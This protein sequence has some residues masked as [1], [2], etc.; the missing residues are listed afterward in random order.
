MQRLASIK[1]YETFTIIAMFIIYGLVF[2][3]RL[4]F[5]LLFPF[6]REDLNLSNTQLGLM[7][8]VY[9]LFWGISC[10]F[11][12]L[13]S[14]I[15]K[16]RKR[17][18]ITLLF[19]FGLA[20]M[21]VGIITSVNVL[22]I[23]RII[24]GAVSGPIISLAQTATFASST[25]KKRGRNLGFIQSGSTILGNMIGPIVFTAIATAFSWRIN[26]FILFI[27]SIIMAIILIKRMKEPVIGD[28][29][30]DTTDK[31]IKVTEFKELFMYR[32]IWFLFI[33]G[34]GCILGQVSFCSFASLF[35]AQVS[36]ANPSQVC[37]WFSVTGLVGFFSMIIIPSLSDRFGRKPVMILSS[38]FSILYPLSFIIFYNNFSLLFITSGIASIFS[39]NLVLALSTLPLE[40]V[41]GKFATTSVALII[42]VGELIGGS[43]MTTIGG[44][45][46]DRFSLFA[47]IW[48]SVGGAAAALIFSCFLKETAPI[49]V[50]GPNPNI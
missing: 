30:Q 34:S 6:L 44:I 40:S 1:S 13:V 36:M 5:S 15:L 19:V 11:F 25:T 31:K 39:G 47:P 14:D 8:S 41:P 3:D 10:F 28:H 22:L 7:I 45:L 42:L 24:L 50:P 12:S 20:T 23:M 32:N 38:L 37:I 4:G 33:I 21:L 49:K 9:S 29:F 46:A 43:L 27:P 48:L 17:L 2:I 26:Y 35:L 18:L 16:S